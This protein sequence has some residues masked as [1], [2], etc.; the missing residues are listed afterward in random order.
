MYFI[1]S[2]III[3]IINIILYFIYKN[4]SIY[5]EGFNK[6]EYLVQNIENNNLASNLLAEVD[7]K[8]HKLVY[9]LE[10]NINQ[11][12]KY[13][14]YIRRLISGVQ[15]M[16]LIENSSD[17]GTSYTINKGDVVALCLRSRNDNSLHNINTIMYVA[18][19]ELS[20]IAC[21]EYGHTVL[22]KN[23]FSFLIR[24]AIKICIYREIIYEINPQEYCGL[25]LNKTVMSEMG[26][27]SEVNSYCR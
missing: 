18:L 2:I 20:H 10:D 11:Y 1:A 14:S 4:N 9:Y 16:K 21:P 25:Y 7:I 13:A 22:F 19:H 5:I 23:I 12:P 8:I 6:K 15:H 27:K 3:I 26:D 24:I 17:Y